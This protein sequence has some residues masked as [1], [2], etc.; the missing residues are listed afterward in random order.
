MHGEGTEAEAA[1]AAGPADTPRGERYA[2]L[3]SL[4]GAMSLGVQ[5]A[6]QI[7]ASS[8]RMPTRGQFGMLAGYA[9]AVGALTAAGAVFV[10]RSG[11]GRGWDLGTAGVQQGGAYS[12]LC[13][14]MEQ[15]GN[16]D[17]PGLGASA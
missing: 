11:R 3:F 16:A 5:T 8:T 13:E 6:V 17:G 7:A 10:R 12:A 14:E 1:G 2:L 15:D 4:N 9:A